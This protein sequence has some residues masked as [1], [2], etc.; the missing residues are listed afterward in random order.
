MKKTAKQMAIE[1]LHCLRCG[2]RWYAEA[3]AYITGRM[4]KVCPRC[5]SEKWMLPHT[6]EKEKY[7][8]H[9]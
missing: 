3:A 1:E 5:K 2:R 4:P 6:K 7:A 9:N 8:S